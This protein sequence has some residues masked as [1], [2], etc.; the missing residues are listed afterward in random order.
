MQHSTQRWHD[1]LEPINPS[2]ESHFIEV[3]LRNISSPEKHRLFNLIPTGFSLS[4]EQ[5]DELINAGR[6]LLRNNPEFK[7]LVQSMQ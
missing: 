5:V 2:L 4:D 3:S 7:A 6:Q 1:E